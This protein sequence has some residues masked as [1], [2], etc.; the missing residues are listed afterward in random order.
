MSSTIPGCMVTSSGDNVVK[1]WDIRGNKPGI[2]L[3]KKLNIG[4][5][6]SLGGSP[7]SGLLFAVGGEREMR[8]LNLKK[9][10]T[11]ASHFELSTAKHVAGEGD[12]DWEVAKSDES[13][14]DTEEAPAQSNK[15]AKKKKKK[16]KNQAN[17]SSDDKKEE[18]N[19]EA[20]RVEAEVTNK[21]VMH[22]SK[23]IKKKPREAA[24]SDV[25][26]LKKKKKSKKKKL[27]N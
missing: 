17:K 4:E 11:V 9:Q 24:A 6:H 20:K 16:K 15:N 25:V 26:T 8:V 21:K 22:E 3:S 27:Q 13:Y 7:D 5:L 2:V 10:D 14:T 1:V 19:H 23:K 12:S 18:S